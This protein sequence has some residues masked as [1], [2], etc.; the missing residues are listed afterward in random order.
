MTGVQTCALPIFMPMDAM[1]GTVMFE[2]FG[3]FP[4]EP[5][6]FKRTGKILK[7]II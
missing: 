5:Q 3:K 7:R 1:R 2:D 6:F 4:S